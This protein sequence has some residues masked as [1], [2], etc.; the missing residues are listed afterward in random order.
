MYKHFIGEVAF[1]LSSTTTMSSLALCLGRSSDLCFSLCSAH[2]S[3]FCPLCLI[4]QNSMCNWQVNA[5]FLNE[6]LSTQSVK[7]CT[8]DWNNFYQYVSWYVQSVHPWDC[9]W[10]VRCGTCRG[11]WGGSLDQQLQGSSVWPAPHSSTSCSTAPGRCLM[12]LH[13]LEVRNNDVDYSSWC[14]PVLY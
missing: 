10:L 14:Q 3:S 4:L 2:Q 11:R 13:Y 6:T 1:S 9:V 12:C 7:S 5:Q 8:I